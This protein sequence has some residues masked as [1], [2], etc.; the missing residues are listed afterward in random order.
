MTFLKRVFPFPEAGSL[1]LATLK[2]TCPGPGTVRKPAGTFGRDGLSGSIQRR[3]K[4]AG[5]LRHFGECVRLSALIN[6]I[7]PS[8]LFD[9]Q[10]VRFKIPTRAPD[11]GLGLSQ[12]GSQ[13]RKRSQPNVIAETP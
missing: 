4:F 9:L 2:N 3:Y 11:A 13:H 5:K 6:N 10:C 7:K 12:L 1:Q 8:S